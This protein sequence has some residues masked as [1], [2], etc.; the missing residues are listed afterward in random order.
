MGDGSTLTA[1]SNSGNSNFYLYQSKSGVIEG[2]VGYNN[3]DQSLATIVY[4]S[5]LTQD[6]IDVEVFFNLFETFQYV[7]L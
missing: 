2:D 5:H 3:A 7:F 4:I 1:S 6:G